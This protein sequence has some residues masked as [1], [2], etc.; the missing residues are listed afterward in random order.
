M[1]KIASIAIVLAFLSGMALNADPVDTTTVSFE[2]GCP[3]DP[4]P[5]TLKW[6]DYTFLYDVYMDVFVRFGLTTVLSTVD[7]AQI[8]HFVSAYLSFDYPIGFS[9]A[10]YQDGQRLVVNFLLK[11]VKE[12]TM[13]IMTT[14]FDVKA[15]KIVAEGGDRANT[16]TREYYIRDGKFVNSHALFDAK[17][18]QAWLK[19][20]KDASAPKN[21]LADMYLF[22]EKPG[23]DSRI[24]PLLRESLKVA[25]DDA[26]RL[27]P[28]MTL[29][30]Y[31]LVS[32][33][34]GKADSLMQESDALLEKSK[35]PENV[36]GFQKC[37]KEQLLMMSALQPA[38]A[39]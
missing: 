17:K 34:I 14:N 9:V 13:M 6:N 30:Q 10:D 33:D 35:A 31:Y 23:N 29:A 32:G 4:A 27:A 2:L 5:N 18:E 16:Y 38:K 39:P 11:K 1:K 24:E 12:D 22:D 36:I 15:M 28:L 37:L 20:K 26:A 25:E 7:K 3:P 19:A 8:V 21:S